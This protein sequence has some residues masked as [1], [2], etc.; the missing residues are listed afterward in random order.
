[1]RYLFSLLLLS[2]LC[3]NQAQATTSLLTLNQATIKE[4][5][6]LKVYVA[7]NHAKTVLLT[8][9]YL[10]VKLPDGTRVYY[11]KHI[12]GVIPTDQKTPFV[13]SW[14]VHPLEKTQLLDI[15]VPPGLIHGNYLWEVQIVKAGSQPDNSENIITTA[16]T[17]LKHNDISYFHIS[18][19]DKGTMGDFSPPI[20]ALTPSSSFTSGASDGSFGIPF[21]LPSN[22][23]IAANILTA[24]DIDDN[25]NYT[26]FK[27]Y[28]TRQLEKNNSLTQN[29]TPLPTFAT[30]DRVKIKVLDSNGVG[31]ANAKIEFSTIA[32]QKTLLKSYTG[33]DGLFYLFPLFDGIN[34]KQLKLN[35]STNENESFAVDIDLAQ[36]TIER[37]L[38]ITANTLTSKLPE[39]L[40]LMF[41]IDTTGSMGDELDYL[42]AELKNIV[43][44]ISDKY[45][46]LAIR[47]GLVVYRDIGD[48]YIVHSSA[49]TQSVDEMEKLLQKQRASGGGDYPEAMEQGLEQA[50]SAPWHTGNTARVA[51]LVADAP[52]HDENLLPMLTLSHT[53]REKG[54]HIYSLA[55]SGVADTAEYLMRSISVLTHSRYLFLTDDSGVGNSHAIPTVPC[56][57]ITK[58]NASIIRAIES[59]LAG[60]RIEEASTGIIKEVGLQQDGQCSSN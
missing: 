36:L 33:S 22:E 3:F 25:L 10:S 45:S 31:L 37:E 29:Q 8:D 42:T 55:A 9:V 13:T 23:Q 4:G 54:V 16:T 14:L 59:E 58:L 18:E 41:I 39:Q 17:L 5:E 1:M 28:I 57:Q 26:D 46:Q 19:S 11:V 24:G 43:T 7:V 6:A 30:E 35:I 56:Y 20:S 2:V 44:V 12:S 40:D 51:F 52:P 48:E 32:P 34:E 60:Q 49:F 47:Y 27:N 38:T 50:L 21:E 15:M 53:A